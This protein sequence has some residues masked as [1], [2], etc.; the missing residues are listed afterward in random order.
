[1]TGLAYATDAGP[2]VPFWHTTAVKKLENSD[3]THYPE[4][5]QAGCCGWLFCDL[6]PA[7]TAFLCGCN[8]PC[9]GCLGI[10]AAYKVGALKNIVRNARAAR[11]H[12]AFLMK[13]ARAACCSHRRR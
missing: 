5:Y 2:Y 13:H 4:L 9:M 3:K 11:V 1:M 7:T 12:R 8:G 6:C 10:N